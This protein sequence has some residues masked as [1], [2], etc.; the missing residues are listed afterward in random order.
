MQIQWPEA[1]VGEISKLAIADPSPAVRRMVAYKMQMMLAADTRA[2]PLS[3]S[4][5]EITQLMPCVWRVCRIVAADVDSPNYV[6]DSAARYVVVSR[7]RRV[8]WAL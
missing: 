4:Q 5:G 7:R 6:R 3:N 8:R 1:V 2:W